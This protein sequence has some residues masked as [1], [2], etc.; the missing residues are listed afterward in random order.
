M[1]KVYSKNMWPGININGFEISFEDIHDFILSRETFGP[2]IDWSSKAILKVLEAV[3]WYIPLKLDRIQS[4]T[5]KN[6]W[7][8]E[9]LNIYTDNRD[10]MNSELRDL[11]NKA[12]QKIEDDDENDLET[13]FI[14]SEK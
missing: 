12:Y 1:E 9:Q 10:V 5:Q 14:N 2:I 6:Q 7:L 4:H 13:P 8:D 3:N 11:F